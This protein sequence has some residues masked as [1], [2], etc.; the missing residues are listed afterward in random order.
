MY[1]HSTFFSSASRRHYKMLNFKMHSGLG[2]S[3]RMDDLM[4]GTAHH[5]NTV[6]R[7]ISLWLVNGCGY[8]THKIQSS[9]KFSFFCPSGTTRSMSIIWR[10][11]ADPRK[12]SPWLVNGEVRNPEG[13][14]LM[15]FLLH[16]AVLARYMLS[17]CV[18]LSVCLSVTSRCSTETVKRRI[19]QTTPHDS[20]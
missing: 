14:H 12:V 7:R 18:C 15:N 6:V 17:S 19:T 20:P 3:P 4:H 8:G 11:G 2:F 10:E 1:A 5:T 9:V 16:D 13:L